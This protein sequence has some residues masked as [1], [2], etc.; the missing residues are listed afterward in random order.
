MST[1]QAGTPGHTATTGG[2]LPHAYRRRLAL[3]IARRAAARAVRARHQA[4][5][6]IGGAA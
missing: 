3:I 1:P 2:S 4:A 6:R 5:Q